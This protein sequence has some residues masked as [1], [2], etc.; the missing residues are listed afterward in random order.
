MPY[1][2]NA[3][4]LSGIS[5]AE[6]IEKDLLARARGSGA[7]LA[8]VQ[9]G[10]NAVSAGY[11]KK[12]QELAERI[13]IGFRMV[14]FPG[15]LSEQEARTEV[16]RVC[17]DISYSSV[18]VQLPLP[19]HMNAQFVLDAIPPHKDP[20]LLS[21]TAFGAFVLGASRI[22]PPTVGAVALLLKEAEVDLRG[23]QVVLVGSGRLVGL[24][25]F[26]WLNKEKATVSVA[27]EYTKDLKRVVEKADVV[28]SGVGKPNLI[29]ARMVKKGAVVI[30]AGTS[31]EGAVVSGDIEF[32]KVAKR[33]SVITPVPGGVGPLTV[34]FLFDNVLKLRGT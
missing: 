23:K 25:L 19:K 14:Q 30:D 20:D 7:C 27:N 16:E 2:M 6:R 29:T 5:L 13:G 32:E 26:V 33:A 1:H 10:E 9:I 8:V 31:V 21:S 12:K 3:R 4:I 18:I 22:V 28:I 24:P 17:A 15:T 11:V 34:C